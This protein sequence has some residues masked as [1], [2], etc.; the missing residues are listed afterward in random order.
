MTRPFYK[1]AWLLLLMLCACGGSSTS[2][3][4]DPRGVGVLTTSIRDEARDRTL[5]VEVWY[6]TESAGTP[7][8]V[9]DFER[10][11]RRATLAPLLEAAPSECVARTTT[12]TRD[13]PAVA[14][15]YPL[16]L[17]T[18]CYTCTRWSAH[19]VVERLVSEGFVVVSADHEGD[20][21]FDSLA[22]MQS[23]LTN[24]LVDVREADVRVLLDQVLD[25]DVLPEGVAAIPSQVGLLGHSIGSV[26]AGRVAQNDMRITAVLG[27]AAPMENILYGEVS[28]ENIEIPVGMIE[29]TEDNSIGAIGNTF[30]E[31]NF[32][33]ANT[34]A[35]KLDIVD[36]GHWSVTNIAGL[37]PGFAPGCGD[38]ERQ[39][40][41]EPFT[42][43]GVSEAKDY[44]ASFASAFFAAHVLDDS[45]ALELL[46]SDPWPSAAP[47]RV[48][49]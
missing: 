32:E 19:A 23:D 11:D 40:S 29:A 43:I 1:I 45:D 16:V 13:A 35:Y 6:P 44:T 14:G 48:R 17:Y 12:A 25:G 36:A 37:T 46:R 27:M 42:Y 33:V 34:P 15:D 26:T 47:L 10:G 38:G 3:G 5:P 39:G 18:H 20:T 8:D 49:E 41:A 21:L 31:Q 4:T 22:G 9:L 30:I 2:S 7:S 24:E 28:M